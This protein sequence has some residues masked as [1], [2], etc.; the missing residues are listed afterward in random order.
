MK[1]WLS[2][3]LMVVATPLW[4]QSAQTA[5]FKSAHWRCKIDA[6]GLSIP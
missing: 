2:L 4:A 1:T 3:W 6:S 5:P